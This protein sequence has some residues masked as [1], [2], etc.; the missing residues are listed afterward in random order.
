MKKETGLNANVFKVHVINSLL[1]TRSV[2]QLR[3]W[4]TCG[5]AEHVA[6]GEFYKELDNK[7]DLLVEI[8]IRK[9]ASKYSFDIPFTST[10][11]VKS[12]E[13]FVLY[14]SSLEQILEENNHIWSL[15]EAN[16][17]EDIMTLIAHTIYKISNLV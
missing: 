7:V 9:D 13:E 17:M 2:A 6:L 14:L 10:D 15:A 3:H 1:A 5:L 16:V 12:S 11:M 4:N 8:T